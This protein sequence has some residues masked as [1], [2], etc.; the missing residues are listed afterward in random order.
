MKA[1]SPENHVKAEKVSTW[2]NTDKDCEEIIQ[3]N[4]N[5]RQNLSIKYGWISLNST[6]ERTEVPRLGFSRI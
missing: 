5:R 4:I 1:Y 2:K 3:K 6:P